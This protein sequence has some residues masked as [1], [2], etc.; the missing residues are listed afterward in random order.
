M[1]YIT[2]RIKFDM[3]TDFSYRYVLEDLL[4]FPQKYQMSHFEG[5]DF[6]FTIYWGSCFSSKPRIPNGWDYSSCRS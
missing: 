6:I 1:S 3:D 4:E 2:T 5:N